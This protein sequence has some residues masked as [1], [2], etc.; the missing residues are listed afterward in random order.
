MAQ[1]IFFG[2]HLCTCDVAS[3]TY[4]HLQPDVFATQAI[5]LHIGQNYGINKQTKKKPSQLKVAF[6]EMHGC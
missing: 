1:L 6:L 2:L 3:S 5:L 4:P